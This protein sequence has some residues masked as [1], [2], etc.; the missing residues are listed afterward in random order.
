MKFI[1]LFLLA[2]D[3]SAQVFGGPAKRIQ[4]GNGLPSAGA[5]ANV[6]NVGAVYVQTNAAASKSSLYVCAN[7]AAGVYNWELSSSGPV[8]GEVN[9]GA[10]VGAAGVNVFDSKVGTTLNFRKLNAASN[11][12]SIVLNGSQVDFDLVPTNVVLSTLGGTLGI[13]QVNTSSKQGTGPKF[14]TLTGP[15]T[16]GCLNLV[17]GEVNSLTCTTGVADPGSNGIM[18]RTASNV[19]AAAIASDVIGL[20]TGCSGSLGLRADGTCGATG[21][22][23]DPGSNGPMKRTSLNTTAPATY[24]DII[25][26]FSGC[27]GTMVPQANGAC[28]TGGGGGAQGF[29][30]AAT[31]VT[32][33]SVN[34]G[35]SNLN[36]L[37]GAYNNSGVAVGFQDCTVVDANNITMTF[38]SA[39]TGRVVV[40]A[41]GGSGGPAGPQGPSVW[42]VITGTLASQTDLNTALG[43]K[44]VAANKG[45]ANGYAGLDGTGKVP[46]A[47]LPAPSGGGT[48][49]SITGT[50]SS[51]T[52][53]NT[54]LAA[55]ELIANK[56]AANGYASL[57]GTGK[58][59]SAQLPTVTGGFSQPVSSVTSVTVNHAL[60]NLNVACFAYGGGDVQVQPQDC[61]IVDSNHVTVTFAVA[62]TG[63]VVILAGGGSGGGGSG[64]ADPAANGPIKRTALNVT[65]PAVAL[66][67]SGLFCG[68]DATKALYADGACRVPAGGSG[69]AVTSDLIKIWDA[70]VTATTL[71]LGAS[72]GTTSLCNVN[73]VA[74]TG[75]LTCTVTSGGGDVAYH[76][77]DAVAKVYKIGTNTT[78]LSC[79][80]GP[81]P[82][83][84]I[85][86]FPP[87]SVGLNTIQTN[88]ASPFW[89]TPIAVRSFVSRYTWADGTGISTQFAG[90]DAT[91]GV[92]TTVLRMT[93]SVQNTGS[94][95]FASLPGTIPAAGSFV[96]CSNC[97]TAG[98]CGAGGTGHMAVS[99]GTAWKC[100]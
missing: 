40:V 50:L 37:C 56:G 76:Y 86:A 88:V 10:N 62:F 67:I 28:G 71:T 43:L 33:V 94:V 31:G 65:A 96:Y 30:Q 6:T 13:G 54:A 68:S 12:L 99:N 14:L 74:M 5:C 78:V 3:L 19:T 87:R 93:S 29:T 95:A 41:G 52:D 16:D 72:C 4:T 25:G 84:G 34:H 36:V 58:V 45:V 81:T 15:A 44:E 42:G 73:G 80:S 64:L 51:Q 82:M 32:T 7:T 49:G 38:A 9:I 61:T 66:D 26:L 97:T 2:A 23:A 57:D 89:G 24:A 1:L 17:G 39:F 75:P 53:L 69:G 90:E 21:G 70:T 92:D 60:S 8:S 55:R 46:S 47:Q 63:R 98:T 18:K 83:L 85:S 91:I 22:V 79:P 11:K 77:F 35:L 48:W 100:D 20:F 59:P 27:S